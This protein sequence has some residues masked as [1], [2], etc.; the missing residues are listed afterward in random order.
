MSDALRARGMEV[1]LDKS[2]LRGGDAWDAAIRRQ[3]K[4]C[5]LFIPIISVSTRARAEGY[6][7]LALPVFPALK[8]DSRFMALVDRMNYPKPES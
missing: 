2:D 1:W 8:N 5:A 6:F 4:T 3:I 7:R